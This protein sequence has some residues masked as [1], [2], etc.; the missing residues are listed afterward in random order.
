M[1]M[2][3]DGPRSIA[4]CG[5]VI[6]NA[7]KAV[8]GRA[9]RV[10]TDEGTARASIKTVL[11]AAPVIVPG[12]DTP[13]IM[14]AGGVE[15]LIPFHW[16]IKATLYPEMPERT[17]PNLERPAGVVTDPTSAEE[18]GVKND[19]DPERKGVMGADIP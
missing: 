13:F 9:G 10:M 4:V 11:A 3:C 17:V 12:H 19:Y 6:K 8:T 18:N 2:F 15:F 1:A 7:W 16:E 14:G 5:D